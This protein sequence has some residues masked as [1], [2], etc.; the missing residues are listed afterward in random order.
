VRCFDAGERHICSEVIELQLRGNRTIAPASIVLP[1]L[2]SDVPVFCRW[3]GEPEFGGPAW[4]QL[5][6][7]VDRLI[8]NSSEWEELQFGKLAE[9]FDQTAISDIAWRRLHEWRVSLARFWPEIREQE[10]HIRG[11]LAEAT[12]LHGWLVSRLDRPVA[13]I[14]LADE[15]SVQLGGEELE[16]PEIEPLSP[17]DLLSA[18]LDRLDRDRIYEQAVL[19]A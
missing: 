15:L 17:S 4:A 8:V 7:V 9:S 11:P 5:V 14:E 10:I 2:I 12:L 6:G 18:E 19:A 13:T 16:P 1:L 3:R